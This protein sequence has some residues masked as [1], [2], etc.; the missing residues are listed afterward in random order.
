MKSLSLIIRVDAHLR[1]AIIIIIGSDSVNTR[2][3]A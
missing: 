3:N 1:V 2:G